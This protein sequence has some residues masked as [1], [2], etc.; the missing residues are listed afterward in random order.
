MSKTLEIDEQK[1]KEIIDNA[2]DTAKD[3]I[4]E[5]PVHAEIILQQL[6]RAVRLPLGDER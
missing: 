2:L 4:M 1:A 6:L 5:K 3:M